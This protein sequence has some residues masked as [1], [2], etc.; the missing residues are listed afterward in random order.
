MPSFEWSTSIF[1]WMLLFEWSTL[2]LKPSLIPR[3]I[4]LT[5]SLGM[6]SDQW[7]IWQIVVLCP[8]RPSFSHVRERGSGHI[9]V[10]HS[11]DGIY[12]WIVKL[13]IQMTT[14]TFEYRSSPFKW[15]HLYL[16]SKVDHSNEAIASMIDH[17]AKWDYN[18]P[19]RSLIWPHSQMECQ[20]YLYQSGNKVH[21]SN[22]SIYIWIVKLTIQMKLLLPWLT[23]QM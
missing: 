8:C 16:D 14:F 18:L 9:E 6:R 2:A 19:Y 17:H 22:D 23:I 15:L 3:L 5:I 7:S 11:N 21:H 12:I 1:K 13:T 20:R 10:D 4:P